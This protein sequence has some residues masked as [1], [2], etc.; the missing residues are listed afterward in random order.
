MSVKA[1]E[2]RGKKREELEQELEKF[3]QVTFN[4][5]FKISNISFN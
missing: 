5:K 1:R 2:V 4:Q 3:R